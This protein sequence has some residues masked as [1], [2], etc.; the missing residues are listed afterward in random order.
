MWRGAHWRVYSVA[1][2]PGLVSGPAR[3]I[4]SSGASLVLDATGRGAIVVRERFVDAWQVAAGSASVS[5]ARG[6]WLRVRVSRPGRV[7]LRIDL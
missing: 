7:E 5:A 2:A 1:G 6:G 4:R 3:L